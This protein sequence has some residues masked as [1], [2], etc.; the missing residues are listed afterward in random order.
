MT[1]A[2]ASPCTFCKRQKAFSSHIHSI[3]YYRCSKILSS[4]AW[5]FCYWFLKTTATCNNNSELLLSV[6]H[7]K[8]MGFGCSN[9]VNRWMTLAVKTLVPRIIE[10]ALTGYVKGGD[11]LIPNIAVIP[12]DV[13]WPSAVSILP[14]LQ[15]IIRAMSY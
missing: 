11:I 10:A 2:T 4:I 15:Q 9:T 1:T 14:H 5:Y 3:L 13:S 12:S 6:K 8:V 7:F